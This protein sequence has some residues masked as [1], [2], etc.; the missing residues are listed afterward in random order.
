[1][2]FQLLKETALSLGLIAFCVSPFVAAPF[3]A[4]AYGNS[5]P[6]RQAMPAEL[7]QYD[8]NNNGRLD[9][10]ELPALLQNYVPKVEQPANSLVSGTR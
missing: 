4:E 1:M 10:D 3:V 5:M 7:R 9:N 8:T 6:K 2:A